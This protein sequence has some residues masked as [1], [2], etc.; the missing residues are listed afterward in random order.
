[1][2]Y[3]RSFQDAGNVDAE[4][5][6]RSCKNILDPGHSHSKGHPISLS[7][8]FSHLSTLVF[9][10]HV[11]A[12]S[13]PSKRYQDLQMDGGDRPGT[14]CSYSST[15]IHEIHELA[16]PTSFN[17][18]KD[19]RLF[20]WKA[21]IRWITKRAGIRMR[22]K[23]ARGR[24]EPKGK[25]TRSGHPFRFCSHPPNTI[26]AAIIDT[27]DKRSPKELAKLN[28]KEYERDGWI[29]YT[30]LDAS[31]TRFGEVFWYVSRALVCLMYILF[32]RGRANSSSKGI[33]SIFPTSNSLSSFLSSLSTNPIMSS[34]SV[35]AESTAAASTA[36]G[37]QA[38]AISTATA[39]LPSSTV[40]VSVVP[41]PGPG[42]TPASIRAEFLQFMVN[43]HLLDPMI[44]AGG[45]SDGFIDGLMNC[46]VGHI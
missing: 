39:P 3:S 9:K 21:T 25:T 43:R 18:A 44:L 8:S 32:A 41:A 17:Q 31:R 46:F 33:D 22:T 7:P 37:L 12:S 15:I 42:I 26:A 38:S 13:V 34:P 27:D 29:V 6:G 40:E 45:Y 5:F 11:F 35:T 20:V 19:L 4:E 14:F 16:L 30:T 28:G 23:D 1:M 10:I 36:L 2:F 24:R